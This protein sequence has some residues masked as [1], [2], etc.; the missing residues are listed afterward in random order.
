MVET[1][2]DPMRCFVIT[3]SSLPAQVV[4]N[5]HC[6]RA[7][8][9]PGVA[10]GPISPPGGVVSIVTVTLSLE[11]P[12][13]G[14]DCS[15]TIVYGPSASEGDVVAQVPDETGAES[16]ATGALKDDAE[17]TLTVTAA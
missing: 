13:A 4:G 10:V 16:V 1:V 15:A 3:T 8:P 17:Y 14:S 11:T 6:K 7:K 12:P 5:A 9:Y 2:D